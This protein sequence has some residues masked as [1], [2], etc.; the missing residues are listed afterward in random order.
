MIPAKTRI[1][2]MTAD[3]H[4]PTIVEIAVSPDPSFSTWK[5]PAGSIVIA[6]PNAMKTPKMPSLIC[7]R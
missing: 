1:R 3:V 2:N 6:V 7:K 5:T 4:T